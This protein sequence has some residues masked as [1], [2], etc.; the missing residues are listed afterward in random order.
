MEIGKFDYIWVEEEEEELNSLQWKLS[1]ARQKLRQPIFYTVKSQ[2]LDR[3]SLCSN[4]RRQESRD[5]ATLRMLSGST[6]SHLNT[7][8][9][10]AAVLSVLPR[11]TY[12]ISG[13]RWMR[14]VTSLSSHF[15]LL[16]HS[17]RVPPQH[18]PQDCTHQSFL[19]CLRLIRTGNRIVNPSQV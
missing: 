15:L 3:N 1:D 16:W 2:T 17:R 19:N 13:C 18:Q 10:A 5:L 12:R 7:W 6:C 8:E 11:I 14:E 9:E 4:N